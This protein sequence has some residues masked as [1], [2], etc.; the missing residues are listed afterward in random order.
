MGEWSE[1]SE[2]S[3]NCSLGQ[4]RGNKTRERSLRNGPPQDPDVQIQP[5]SE[6]CPPGDA[7]IIEVFER[8]KIKFQN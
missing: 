1:W 6:Q 8:E 7:S 3:A 2:C 5:C 4:P